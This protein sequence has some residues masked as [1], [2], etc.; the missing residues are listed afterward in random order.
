MSTQDNL[1]EAFGGESQANRRYLAFARQADEDGYSLIAKLFRVAADAET[2][3]ALAHLKVLGEVGSTKENLGEAVAGERHESENMYP[4]FI[5]EAKQE[6]S[7][8]AVR[9]FYLASKVEEKHAD[10]FAKVLKDF[11]GVENHTY[12]VCQVCG[13]PAEDE[14]PNSCPN[15]G[16]SASAFKKVE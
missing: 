13:W 2:V 9:S 12:Y 1:Q 8:K 6:D 16:A 5:E 4:K 10:I 3:H 7:N 11:E 15:C 14:I